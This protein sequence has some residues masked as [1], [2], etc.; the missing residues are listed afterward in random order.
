MVMF[1]YMNMY[2]HTCRLCGFPPFYSTGGAPISPGMKKRIR[3]GQY[4]FPDPEWTNVSPGGIVHVLYIHIFELHC[5]AVQL[6]IVGETVLGVS[7]ACTYTT[8]HVHVHVCDLRQLILILD[9]VF[10]HSMHVA[11]QVYMYVCNHHN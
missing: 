4:T 9:L 5:C 7:G 11:S 6:S 3:Q 2:I 8:I 1:M 10:M